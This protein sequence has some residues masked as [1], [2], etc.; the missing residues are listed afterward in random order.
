MI[1]ANIGKGTKM[2]FTLTVD[3]TTLGGIPLAEVTNFKV[4]FYAQAKKDSEITGY[5]TVLKSEATF[6][7]ETGDAYVVCDTS[8]IDL[9]QISAALTV[10]YADDDTSQT[11]KEVIPMTTDV[12][13][14]EVGNSGGIVA[15]AQVDFLFYEDTDV[16]GNAVM[17][18]YGSTGIV[19]NPDNQLGI[20]FKMITMTQG[21]GS[22]SKRVGTAVGNDGWVSGS[23]VFEVGDICYCRS[24]RKYYELTATLSG[25]QWALYT[26]D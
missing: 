20:D 24:T 26:G 22:S 8:L 14:V 12:R 15:K 6:D 5:C 25:V 19:A 10:E 11:L 1:M 13:V 23:N 18:N 16:T 21:G 3:E 2:K 17:Y 9:G 7:A 4:D